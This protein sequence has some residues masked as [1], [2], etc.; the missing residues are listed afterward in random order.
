MDWSPSPIVLPVLPDV[1]TPLDKKRKCN[2]T[3]PK[4]ENHI[5]QLSDGVS[6][7]I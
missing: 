7:C 2:K 4:D 3:K 1:C 5:M 6:I